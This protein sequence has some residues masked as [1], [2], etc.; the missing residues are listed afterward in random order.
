MEKK[1]GLVLDDSLPP[2]LFF[3]EIKHMLGQVSETVVDTLT[4]LHSIDYQAAGLNMIGKPNDIQ[5]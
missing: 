5:T 2:E 3:M 1:V 4:R